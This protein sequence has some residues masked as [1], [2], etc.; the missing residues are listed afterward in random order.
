LVN[1]NVLSCLLKD[2]RQVD[3]IEEIIFQVFFK[4]R[5]ICYFGF[6][7]HMYGPSMNLLAFVPVQNFARF[8]AVV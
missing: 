5:A 4:M 3:A 6:V 7:I 1:K 8:G 2:G